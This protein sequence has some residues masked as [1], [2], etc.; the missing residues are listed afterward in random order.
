M[1]KL[2]GKEESVAGVAVEEEFK[3]FK[4]RKTLYQS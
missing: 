2:V 4:Y 3:Y 1:Q